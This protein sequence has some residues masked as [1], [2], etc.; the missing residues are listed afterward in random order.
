[1]REAQ[2]VDDSEQKLGNVGCSLI[3]EAHGNESEREGLKYHSAESYGDATGSAYVSRAR[4]NAVSTAF[5]AE[6]SP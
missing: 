6:G 1:M 4:R 5:F 2:L 3:S